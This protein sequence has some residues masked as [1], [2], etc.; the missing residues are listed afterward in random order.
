MQHI[1]IV[2]SFVLLATAASTNVNGQTTPQQLHHV[3]L[4]QDTPSIATHH[5]IATPAVQQHLHTVAQVDTTQAAMQPIIA[6]QVMHHPQ[7]QHA[8]ATAPAPTV[9]DSMAKVRWS[10]V[11]TRKATRPNDT[12]PNAIERGFV[13]LPRGTH[14]AYYVEGLRAVDSTYAHPHW[15]D[16]VPSVALHTTGSARPVNIVFANALS[17]RAGDL[18]YFKEARM[19]QAMLQELNLRSTSTTMASTIGLSPGSIAYNVPDS[20]NVGTTYTVEVRIIK[21]GDSLLFIGVNEDDYVVAA[22][23]I[24]D[25]AEAS[26]VDPSGNTN[27]TITPSAGVE[28]GVDAEMAAVWQWGVKPL[29]SGPLPLLLTI[30][31]KPNGGNAKNIPVFSRTV[32]VKASFLYRVSGFVFQYWQWLLTAVVVPLL[33]YFRK[34]IM[35][36]MGRRNA[37][38]PAGF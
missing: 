7:W 1:T 33:L 8:I 10:R 19:G 18:P 17:G 24:A 13:T 30:T 26:L 4:Q 16:M 32:V 14:T 31:T 2:C 29:R 3:V 37:R 11:I 28:L 25:I 23:N 22:I 27:F 6:T 15:L 5:V 20:M 21:G 36:A 34:R 38:K 12:V 9:Q 35:A